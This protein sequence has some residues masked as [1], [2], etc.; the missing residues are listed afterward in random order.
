MSDKTYKI[1]DLEWEQDDEGLWW[2]DGSFESELDLGL[3][4]VVAESYWY[5]AGDYR[6]ECDSIED[7][8]AKAEAH[9]RKLLEGC[10]EE[11]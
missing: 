11:V 2:A 5:L 9:Y 4:F 3:R 8:K 6:H 7:G 10:L 1:R